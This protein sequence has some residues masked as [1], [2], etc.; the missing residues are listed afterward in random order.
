MKFRKLFKLFTLFNLGV[1]RNKEKRKLLN[2]EISQVILHQSWEDDTIP[3]N[4]PAPD[5]TTMFHK[6]E[7]RKNSTKN[8]LK[9][10]YLKLG[11]PIM[12]AAG[13][14]ILL[15]FL[16]FPGS[17]FNKDT[18]IALSELSTNRG[19]RKMLLLSDGT[20]VYLNAESTIA[21][22]KEFN[23]DEREVYITGEVYFE[24]AHDKTKLFRVHIN[25]LKINVLGTKF[26]VKAYAGDSEIETVLTLGKIEM[27]VTPN[28]NS[29]PIKRILLPKQKGVFNTINETIETSVAN[30]NN[31]TAWTNGKLVFD[32]ENLEDII[33]KMERWYN[34]E[35]E[36]D[37]KLLKQHKLT[38]TLTNETVNEVMV[39]ITKATKSKF[40]VVNKVYKI[41]TLY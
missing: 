20:K 19:E 11:W 24:V 13:I 18:K 23:S 29:K 9:I 28:N 8:K 26:N 3:D 41:E 25:N 27:E 36:L 4:L 2:S 7:A 16:L 17:T 39:L 21:Y 32:N 1:A 15:F 5:F 34:V 22:P 38:M 6:I 30:I 31:A 37:N 10:R 33:I 35:I 14:L 12:A 40:T